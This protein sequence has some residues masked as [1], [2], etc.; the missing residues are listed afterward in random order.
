MSEQQKDGIVSAMQK[1]LDA[2][3]GKHVPSE[4]QPTDVW[5]KG[6]AMHLMDHH[7]PHVLM[8]VDMIEYRGR[9]LSVVLDAGFAFAYIDTVLH[10][11][12]YENRAHTLW[13]RL[14]KCVDATVDVMVKAAAEFKPGMT[15]RIT[16]QDPTWQRAT[17]SEPMPGMTAKV[18]AMSSI[19]RSYAA[20]EGRVT[21]EFDETML[22]YE[23]SDKGPITVTYEP[24]RLEAV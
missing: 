13:D 2:V 24:Q 23:P 11:Q 1:L 18:V 7:N 14:I 19:L 9:K 21:L 20:N 5:H 22:G 17:C 12:V 6:C 8:R 16:S 4:P 3:E 10:R 15:V